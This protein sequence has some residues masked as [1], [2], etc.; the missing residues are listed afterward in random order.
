MLVGQIPACI[1]P[2]QCYAYSSE[3]YLPKGTAAKSLT[4]IHFCIVFC[5]Q[6]LKIPTGSDVIRKGLSAP[7]LVGYL[8]A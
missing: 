2:H 6:S 4:T 1:A 8:L 3:S 7:C 5:I